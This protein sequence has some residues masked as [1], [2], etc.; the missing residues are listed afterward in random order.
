MW[1][2][3]NHIN[4]PQ[5]NLSLTVIEL[6]L[7]LVINFILDEIII[8]NKKIGCINDLLEYLLQLG[9]LYAPNYSVF[10]RIISVYVYCISIWVSKYYN[11]DSTHFAK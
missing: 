4:K 6:F 8:K 7:L 5:Y 3:F 9:T 1:Y 11:W 10:L 2:I